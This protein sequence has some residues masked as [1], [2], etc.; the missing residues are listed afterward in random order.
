MGSIGERLADVGFRLWWAACAL[1]PAP[2]RST[3]QLL[4]V[5][6]NRTHANYLAAVH[7][8]IAGDERL[9]CYLS[10]PPRIVAP[11]DA[12]AVSATLQLEHVGY[13]SA[14]LRRWDLILFADQ[15]YARHFSRHR[16]KILTNH[17]IAGGKTASAGGHSYRYGR[18][19]TD[20]HGRPRFTRIFEASSA[21]RDRA[22]DE[23]PQFKDVIAVVG[24][25]NA[26]RLLALR[27]RR[28]EFR[29]RLGFEAR[30]TV[31]LIQSTWGPHSLM[32]RFGPQLVAEARKL[33]D[34]YRFVFSAHPLQ[35]G[36]KPAHMRQFLLDQQSAGTPLR[37]PEEDFA[38]Y[39]IASDLAVSDFTSLTV[40]YALLGK[41]LIL[42]PIDDALLVEHLPAWQLVHT[43]PVLRAP[44]ELDGAITSALADYPFEQMEQITRQVN[45]YPGQ[46]AERIR[47]EVYR[48]LQLPAP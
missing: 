8:L 14:R 26:D 29:R 5:G 25:L 38:P 15:S 41:P 7:E 21:R 9:A 47:N 16:R 23:M 42:I 13:L 43:C 1:A 6:L 4:F 32:E 10:V 48:L 27:P 3:R 2:K 17:G 46:A 36:G 44:D 12:D 34:K 39:M 22:V 45:S 40:T 30:D 37:R 28:D 35:W 33:G 11:E 31:V 24:D 20:R 19:T 18:L